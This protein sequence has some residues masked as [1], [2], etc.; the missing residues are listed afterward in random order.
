MSLI[1]IVEDERNLRIAID[2]IL[3]DAGHDVA[4]TESAK[5]AFR[6][7][8]A[9][10]FDLVI[11]DLAMPDMDGLELIRCLRQS[12]PDLPVLAISGAFDGRFLK[13][14]TLLGA[15]AA[16]DKPFTQDELLAMVNKTRSTQ[17]NR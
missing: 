3:K 1:L 7:C 5:E 14:A 12:H 16:L 15:V 10:P 9:Q 17:T 6:L 8:Q 11:T 4:Q 2:T 13:V